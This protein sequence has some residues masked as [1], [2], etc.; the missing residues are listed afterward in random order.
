MEELVDAGIH[1][2][3][4]AQLELHKLSPIE[5]VDDLW[6]FEWDK[7]ALFDVMKEWQSNIGSVYA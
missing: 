2:L 3:L 7:E 5:E 1:Q 4:S 6:W